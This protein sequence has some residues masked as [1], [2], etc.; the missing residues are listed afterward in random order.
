MSA[1][2]AFLNNNKPYIVALLTAISAGLQVLGYNI[3]GY[4]YT[5]LAAFG[6]TVVHS[7]M[8]AAIKAVAPPTETTAKK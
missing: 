1:I 2:L 5:L 4:V 6:I 3:P 7:S 8:Q